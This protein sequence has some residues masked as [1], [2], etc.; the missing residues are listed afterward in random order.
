MVLRRW[1]LTRP[2]TPGLNPVSVDPRL[3]PLA[4]T[5]EP[6]PCSEG[7]RMVEIA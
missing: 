5:L 7:L 2:P 3:K 6:S 4:P 1:R